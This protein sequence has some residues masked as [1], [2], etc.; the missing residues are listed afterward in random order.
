M[1]PDSSE[2]V[3]LTTRLEEMLSRGYQQAEYILRFIV[4]LFWG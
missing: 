3:S 1:I 2:L 4:T